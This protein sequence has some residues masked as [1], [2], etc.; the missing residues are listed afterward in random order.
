[1][2]PVVKKL[3]IANVAIW[4][5]GQVILEQYFL[6]SRPLL[7]FFALIPRSVVESFYIWQP[8]TYMFLH[9]LSITHIVF[10]TLM[11]WWLGAELE[12]RWGSRLFLTYYL[13]SGAG[14]G[15][16]YTIGITVY[17]A[18]TGSVAGLV[19]PVIGASGA[20]FGLLLAFGI[21]FSERVI[22]FF[23]VFPMKVKYFV[24]I[25]AAIEVVSLLNVGSQK[26]VANL[27]HLGGLISGY[28]FLIF[29]TRSQ[30]RG[31][32]KN[33]K[34]DRRGLRLVVNNEG[35]EKGDKGPKYW[36]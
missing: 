4:L 12:T 24:M 35:E 29:W 36:N 22:L 11:L 9:S 19:A 7:Q 10:N 2:T 6:P 5:V 13:V 26:G 33:A 28:L 14:A 18:F 21:L 32:R 20:V 27:A 15:V 25:I 23:F 30:Q 1:M 17:S 3:I 8:L 34:K 31:R 16:I